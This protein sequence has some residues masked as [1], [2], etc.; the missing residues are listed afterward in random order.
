M[1]DF[2]FLLYVFAYGLYSS[3]KK[4]LHHKAKPH[5]VIYKKSILKCDSERLKIK[6]CKKYTRMST[7]KL[8]H[9][10]SLVIIGKK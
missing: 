4:I 6:A 2:K 7:E 9:K 1:G 10:Y 3:I 5:Y 8:V